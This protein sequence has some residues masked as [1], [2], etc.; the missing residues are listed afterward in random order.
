[1]LVVNNLSG[2]AQAVQPGPRPVRRPRAGGAAR[3]HGV[4]R[5]RR[6]AR[7]RSPSAPT[8]SSGSP[9]GPR[10]QGRARR[11]ATGA[12]R[13]GW[14][15]QD[16]AVLRE[17]GAGRPVVG[18]HPARL[19]ARRS[20]GS[21]ARPARSRRSSS[22]TTRWSSPADGP[23]ILLRGGARR[24]TPRARR[25]STS[26]PLSV[27]PAGR[28]G[29]A[30]PIA[31]PL[32]PSSARSRFYEALLDAT[33]TPRARCSRRCASERARGDGSAAASPASAP[34]PSR[35]WSGHAHP[36]AAGSPRSRATPPSSSATA[37]SSR[38]SASWSR[39]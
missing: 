31:H 14:A 23:R 26:C 29:G 25:S 12:P 28:R 2:S 16:A 27:P 35:D 1:M 17:P 36:G 8:A 32:P 20:A 6:D 21:A 24:T 38:S 4:P 9:S 30:E 10:A 22:T 3:A 13:P 11:T 37:S 33:A 7:T 18:A 5:H 34:P 19:G 39:G 15:E